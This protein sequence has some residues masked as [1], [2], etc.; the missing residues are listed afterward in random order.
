MKKKSVIA[1]R[2]K[3]LNIAVMGLPS[4][5]IF[6]NYVIDEL[7]EEF[8]LCT[9]AL[10][11]N[12]SSTVSLFTTK[13]ANFTLKLSSILVQVYPRAIKKLIVGTVNTTLKYRLTLMSKNQ[14]VVKNRRHKFK[15][16]ST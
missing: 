4:L 8:L 1:M 10:C 14:I 11:G 12:S 15:K 9:S 2:N 7:V 13:L 3:Q 5:M 16:A 6:V